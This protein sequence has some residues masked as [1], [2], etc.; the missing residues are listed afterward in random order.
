L[1]VVVVVVVVAVVHAGGGF[2][3]WWW[4]GGGG[5]PALLR[6]CF[7]ES[8]SVKSISCSLPER[9]GSSCTMHL[10]L[11]ILARVVVRFLPCDLLTLEGLGG[12]GRDEKEKTGGTEMK[13]IRGTTFTEKL[14]SW[15]EALMI[16]FPNA[17]LESA[18]GPPR[19]P[20]FF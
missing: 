12:W 14:G 13:E 5:V 3:W 8:N 2:W 15:N 7:D 1:V 19:S 18:V 20:S 17:V 4:C 11:I 10:A 16:R 9:R 6:L